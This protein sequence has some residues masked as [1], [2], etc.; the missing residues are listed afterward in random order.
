MMPRRQT[1]YRICLNGT[2]RYDIGIVDIPARITPTTNIIN[3]PA[4]L[5]VFKYNVQRNT[6]AIATGVNRA[7]VPIRGN[8]GFRENHGPR[9]E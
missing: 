4:S 8:S 5:L 7:T 6:V 9:H 2:S 3:L 1:R